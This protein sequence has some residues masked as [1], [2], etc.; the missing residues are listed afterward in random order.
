MSGTG[1]APIFVDTGGFYARADEDDEHHE[2]AI[3]LFGRIRSGDAEY[4]PIY[5]EARRKPRPLGRG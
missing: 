5:G 1:A 2:D 3:R 4:Q